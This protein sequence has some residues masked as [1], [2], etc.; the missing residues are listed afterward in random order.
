MSIPAPHRSEERCGIEARPRP[1][2]VAIA[3]GDTGTEIYDGD[4]VHTEHWFPFS[5]GAHKVYAGAV[6][7]HPQNET[8]IFRARKGAIDQLVEDVARFD[9]D[10]FAASCYVWSFR[11][12]VGAVERLKHLR[13]DRVI[14][15]G[16][17]CA[18][19]LMFDRDP[20]RAVAHHIDVLVPR[21]GETIMPAILDLPVIDS[22][23]LLKLPGTFVMTPSGFAQA[24][25]ARPQ[26][27][28]DDMPSPFRLGL[29]PSNATGF[30]ETFRGCPL[31][32]NFC[33]WGVSNDNSRVAS[34]EWLVEELSTLRR[35]GTQSMMIVDAGFNLNNRAFNNLRAAEAEV[36]L[37]R[38]AH[39]AFEIYPDYIRDVH[40]EF[41]SGCK[42]THAGMGLQSSNPELLEL[43]HRNFSDEKF[44]RGV[45]RMR[46]VAVPTIEIIFGLPGD[47]PAGFWR[48]VDYVMDVARSGPTIL[49]IFHALVLPDGLMTR[50]PEGAEMDFDPHSLMMRS[51]R[52]WSAADIEQT[53]ARLGSLTSIRTA[54]WYQIRSNASALADAAAVSVDP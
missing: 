52:G 24:P 32:C 38:D 29:A 1:R 41:L 40:I 26:Q 10:V 33:E 39:I 35:L 44:R 42:I 14:V 22:E 12:M 9:P 21:E 16:G 45:N 17:P 34:R 51:C 7:E 31:S 36:R 11:T 50:A 23:A 49:S 6:H 43:S 25:G 19:P 53:A 27:P 18:H 54:D 28:L 2:R 4:V 47:T 46:Q 5:Y 30:L 3:Y 20:Y 8:R 15:L 13:P 37:F 48:T